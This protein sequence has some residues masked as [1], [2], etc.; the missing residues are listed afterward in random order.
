MAGPGRPRVYDDMLADVILERIAAGESMRSICDDDSL[1]ARSTVALW[2]VND[3]GGFSDRYARARQA[4][5]TLLAD[6]L[7]DIA[8]DGTNDYV[9]SQNGETYN[10][11]AV[12][13][14]RLR[15]DTRKWYLARMLPKVYGDKVAH[16]LTGEGGGPIH[17]ITRTIVDPSDGD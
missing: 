5:A 7:M 12:A 17:T 11:E 3:E 13:R 4:Q 2:I 1:P 15:V 6:E 8:D 9:Q 14:S 16:E 10:G